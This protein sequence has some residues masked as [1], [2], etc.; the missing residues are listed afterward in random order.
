MPKPPNSKSRGRP[1]GD[2]ELRLAIVAE[3]YAHTV[4]HQLRDR[5]DGTARRLADQHLHYSPAT[6]RSMLTQARKFGLLT[7]TSPGKA[8]GSLTHKA[9]QNSEDTQPLQ[10]P[11]ERVPKSQNRRPPAAIRRAPIPSTFPL[12]SHRHRPDRRQTGGNRRVTRPSP[13][14]TSHPFHTGHRNGGQSPTISLNQAGSAMGRAGI[15]PTTLG[16][17]V[18]CS[19][20]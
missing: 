15:E 7:P 8:G 6:I 3:A 4:S 1:K 2:A 11:L 12:H 5:I 9:K 20:S 10:I 18:P 16:L 19:T 17:K 13:T 14:E